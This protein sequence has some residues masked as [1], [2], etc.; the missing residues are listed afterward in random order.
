M[1]GRHHQQ[2]LTTPFPTAAELDNPTEYLQTAAS[3]SITMASR[4]PV[5]LIELIYRAVGGERLYNKG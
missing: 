4:T 3:E 2:M 5:L 1:A